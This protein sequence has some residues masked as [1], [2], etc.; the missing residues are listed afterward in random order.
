MLRRADHAK[1]NG[2]AFDRPHR[3]FLL[4]EGF[5]NERDD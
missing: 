4:H 1:G 3:P 2:P 5:R